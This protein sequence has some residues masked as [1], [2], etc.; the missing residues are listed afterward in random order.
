MSSQAA[1]AAAATTATSTTCKIEPKPKPAT[2]PAQAAT[3][4][5]APKREAP[6]IQ[7]FINLIN[8][9]KPNIQESVTW[10]VKDKGIAVVKIDCPGEKVYLQLII[11]NLSSR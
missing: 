3:Q 7:S 10:T 6:S 1:P 11:K 2:T 9:M 8:L 4:E 5:M